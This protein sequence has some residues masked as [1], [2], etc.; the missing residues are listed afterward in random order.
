MPHR[1]KYPLAR[2]SPANQELLAID[3]PREQ[4]VTGNIAPMLEVLSPLAESRENA[5]RF[6]GRVTFFFSGWD[7]DPR[8]TAEIPE[9]RQWFADLTADFPYWLHLIEKEGAPSFTCSACCVRGTSSGSRAAWSDG[10]SMI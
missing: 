9:I 1:I 6:E 3:F 2:L 8:E 7:E 5:E 4:V 10:A